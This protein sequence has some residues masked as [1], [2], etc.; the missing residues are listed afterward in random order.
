MTTLRGVY[1]QPKSEPIKKLYNLPTEIIVHILQFVDSESIVNLSKVSRILYN[2]TMTNNWY[3]LYAP[4]NTRQIMTKISFMNISCQYASI[5]FAELTKLQKVETI[6]LDREWIE[7]DN[8]EIIFYHLLSIGCKNI[9]FYFANDADKIYNYFPSEINY[10]YRYGHAPSP[11]GTKGPDHNYLSQSEIKYEKYNKKTHHEIFKNVSDI[12]KIYFEQFVQN[13][14][15]NSRFAQGMHL[16]S[17]GYNQEDSIIFLCRVKNCPLS[18][19]YDI[20]KSNR[21]NNKSQ[22]QSNNK[23]KKLLRNKPITKLENYDNKIKKL[24]VQRPKPYIKTRIHRQ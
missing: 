4:H 5:K 7:N 3:Q 9:I 15:S 2:I 6:F 21:D 22:K 8:C 1:I 23:K 16:Y 12:P 10:Y 17:S 13:I 24:K 19:S 14:C 20:K 18:Y 11:V